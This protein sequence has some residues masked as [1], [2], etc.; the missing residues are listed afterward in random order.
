MSCYYG[1]LETWKVVYYPTNRG[2]GQMGVALIE[3]DTRQSAMYSFSQQYA[4][5]YTT[6][7]SCQKLLG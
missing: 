6:I 7:K 5:Q 3:A 1:K 4:G 2:A